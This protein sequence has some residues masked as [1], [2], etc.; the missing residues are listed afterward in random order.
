MATI[1]GLYRR[2]ALLSVLGLSLAGCSSNSS[3]GVQ[4]SGACTMAAENSAVLGTARDWYLYQDLLPASLDP[5]G[6]ATSQAFLDAITA[7]ARAQQKDREWSFLIT[8]QAAQ[9]YFTAGQSAG[10]GL[11]LVIDAT[12]NHLL[13]QQVLGG[14][15]A[16]VAG[17]QRGDDILAI[18]TATDNLVPMATLL[19]TTT[20][21][22]GALGSGTPGTRYFQVQPVG[23]TVPLIRIATSVAAYDLDPVVWKVLPGN[24][25]YVH[26]RTF[27]STAEAKLRTAFSDFHAKGI[28]NVIVDVR[29]NGGG[30]LSTANVL[31]SL[32]HPVS[33]DLMYRFAFNAKHPDQNTDQHFSAEASGLATVNRVAFITTGD[34]ASASELV[35]NALAAYLGAT[36]LAIVGDRTYGKPVGQASFD[37]GDSCADA[38]YLISFA[39]Q[40]K[41][42]YGGYYAGLPTAD[43][44]GTSCQAA[45]DLT[46][47]QGDPAED[48]TQKA[49]AFA[50]TGACG[51]SVIAS[52]VIPGAL[53]AAAGTTTRTLL[54][55]AAPSP[56]QRDI[57]GLY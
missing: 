18:G 47:E 32:L 5:N 52:A 49:L 8:K 26:L 45:D 16:Q 19:A 33:T 54:K 40:N 41:D 38:L 11:G 46:H 17:F 6:Y 3:P 31:G 34:S 4:V 43:F 2:A 14:S 53:R 29:Y 56:A 36:R 28:Q 39:L 24:V 44:K 21:L 42:G 23:T 48:S 25:G 13:V 51:S 55:P 57:P 9:Q 27:V 1:S 20:G 50:T 10:F 15:P 35:P 12:S 30:L 7:N 37:L 22:S